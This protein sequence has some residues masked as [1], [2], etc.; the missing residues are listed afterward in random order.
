[1]FK[2]HDAV[3]PVKTFFPECAHYVLCRPEE[4]M[5]S[6]AGKEPANR[7]KF[8]MS[9]DAAC[10]LSRRARRPVHAP[11]RSRA[12]CRLLRTERARARVG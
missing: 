12:E 2:L 7:T 6:E 9:L 11:A 5:G 1:M 3:L 8:S 4:R 10:E